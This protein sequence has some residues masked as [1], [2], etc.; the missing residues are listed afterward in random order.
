MEKGDKADMGNIIHDLSRFTEDLVKYKQILL[1]FL[2][3]VQ[4]LIFIC[5]SF[6][7]LY[8]TQERYWQRDFLK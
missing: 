4:N 3:R 8:N 7:Y 6:Y 2:K 1:L 5:F